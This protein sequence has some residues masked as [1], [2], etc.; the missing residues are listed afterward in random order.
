MITK[1]VQMGIEIC[2]YTIKT[3]LSCEIYGPLAKHAPKILYLSVLLV[4]N[5]KP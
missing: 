5:I 2:Y 3:G 4:L 1:I